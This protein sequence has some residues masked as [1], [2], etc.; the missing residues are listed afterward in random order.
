MTGTEATEGGVA[1]RV[2]RAGVI[3]TARGG[4]WFDDLHPDS[5]EL[6]P[7]SH[8]GCFVA[9]PQTELVAGCDL[10]PERLRAFGQR[11]GVTALYADYR[12]M[13]AKERLDVVG[14]ATS[15]GHTHAEIAPDVAAA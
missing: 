3:G 4:S 12:E 2:Y 5:P 11:W 15:W 10:D 13:L 7:S 8:A 1:R 9:H 14:I 6:I